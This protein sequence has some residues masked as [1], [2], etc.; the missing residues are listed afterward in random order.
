MRRMKRKRRRER[1]RDRREMRE[2]V[3]GKKKMG[4]SV[5]CVYA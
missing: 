3:E 5:G 2:D 4:G 1:K